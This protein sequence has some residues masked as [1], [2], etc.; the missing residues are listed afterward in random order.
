[1]LEE[2]LLKAVRLHIRQLKEEI[3]KSEF[4][5][6]GDGIL[7]TSTVNGHRVRTQF[8]RNNYG[9]SGDGERD[10]AA[11]WHEEEKSYDVEFSVDGEYSK[12]QDDPPSSRAGLAI[13]DHVKRVVKSFIHHHEPKSLSFEPSD[14]D[15]KLMSTKDVLYQRSLS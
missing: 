15:R 8:H 14:N 9:H 10:Q 7:H 12:N 2:S 4:K 5:D 3:D 1:M 13:A 11:Q 6:V